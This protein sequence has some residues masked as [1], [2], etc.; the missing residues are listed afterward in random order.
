[1]NNSAQ[2]IISI[3][4]FTDPFSSMIHLLAALLFLV[5]SVILLR[6]SKGNNLRYFFLAFFSFAG[7]FQLAISGTYHILD[8]GAGRE[9]LQ[10]IDHAAIFTLIAAS[11]TAIN[12]IIF[13]GF[14]RWGF[15]FLIW[16][17]SITSLV[18]KTIFFDTIPE[19]VGFTFYLSLGWLGFLTFTIVCK[20]F[21][22]YYN[23]YLIYGG[24]AYTIG[25]VSEFS[26]F[27]ILIKGVIGSHEIHHIAVVIG[28]G[29]H[30]LYIYQFA[31]GFVTLP[32]G[33]VL[34]EPNLSV[35]TA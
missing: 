20:R 2:N 7:I 28:I 23:R 24:I 30:W 33:E 12:G 17:V 6:K 25:A 18:I 13:R 8:Y 5:L 21:G 16:A 10:R 1:M 14:M 4:G 3:S 11:F 9:V 34:F 31:D 27:P 35:K 29:C 15:L 32:S 22:I 26:Q 19:W